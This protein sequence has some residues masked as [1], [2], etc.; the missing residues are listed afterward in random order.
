MSLISG[1]STLLYFSEKRKREETRNDIYND[2]FTSS[3]DDLPTMATSNHEESTLT[4]SRR[5][6]SGS[7]LTS[8][9][10]KPTNQDTLQSVSGKSKGDGRPSANLMSPFRTFV[11]SE[12]DSLF[13]SDPSSW[14][15]ISSFD[16]T[17]TG[18]NVPLSKLTSPGTTGEV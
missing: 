13:D 9:K 16:K 10:P 1:T 7:D 3:T 17:S 8:I 4:G 15:D 14:D 6:R 11:L 5:Q 18:K 2:I 12:G